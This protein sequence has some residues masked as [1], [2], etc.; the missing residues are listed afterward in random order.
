MHLLIVITRRYLKN[1]KKFLE[2][3]V[4]LFFFGRHRKKSIYPNK[5]SNEELNNEELFTVSNQTKKKK[6]F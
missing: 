5:R 4:F 3:F 2:L 6:K 1:A